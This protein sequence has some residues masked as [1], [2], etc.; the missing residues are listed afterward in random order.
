MW[1]HVFKLYLSAW[2]YVRDGPNQTKLKR[3]TLRH[4]SM[5]E[6]LKILKRRLSRILKLKRKRKKALIRKKNC[7]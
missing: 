6:E 2:S 5:K 7:N 3:T 1:Y 4:K